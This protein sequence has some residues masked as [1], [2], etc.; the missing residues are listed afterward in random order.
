MRKK[1]KGSALLWAVCSL[2]IVVFVITGILALNKTYATEEINII[3]EK[4]AG[5]YARSVVELTA[6]RIEKKNLV[7]PERMDEVIKRFNVVTVTYG[8]EGCDSD[9]YA[10]VEKTNGDEVRIVAHATAGGQESIATGIM[11]LEGSRWVFKGY[12]TE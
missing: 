7:E 4:R 5:Y 9:P 2:M 11:K 8:I 6:D 12:A 10:V 1:L 3:A